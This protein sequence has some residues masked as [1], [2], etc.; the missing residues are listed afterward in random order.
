MN[1][2]DFANA[3]DGATILF[4]IGEVTT[5]Q[6]LIVDSGT[7]SKGKTPG[8]IGKFIVSTKAGTVRYSTTKAYLQNLLAPFGAAQDNISKPVSIPIY[9]FIGNSFYGDNF[10][11][12]YVATLDRGKGK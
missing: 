2:A 11:F 9:I 1:N 8:N 10:T 3:K 5:Y 7:L 4:V 6:G 12:A